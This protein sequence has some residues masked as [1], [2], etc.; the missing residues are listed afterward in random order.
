MAIAGRE[1]GYVIQINTKIANKERDA[2]GSKPVIYQFK[3]TLSNVRPPVWRRVQVPA[4]ITLYR[5]AAGKQGKCLRHTLK[6]S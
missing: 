6:E 2:R 3:V 1:K 5:L 4:D